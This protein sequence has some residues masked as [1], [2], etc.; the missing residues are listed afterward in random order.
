MMN[1]AAFDSMIHVVASEGYFAKEDEGTELLLEQNDLNIEQLPLL[2]RLTSSRATFTRRLTLRGP[3]MTEVEVRGE[4]DSRIVITPLRSSSVKWEI[5]ALSRNEILKFYY[6][7]VNC[8]ESPAFIN[9]LPLGTVQAGYALKPGEVTSSPEKP[10]NTIEEAPNVIRTDYINPLLTYLNPLYL[11]KSREVEVVKT[12]FLSAETKEGEVYLM[13]K[14]P[15]EVRNRDGELELVG[16]DSVVYMASS[17]EFSLSD[18]LTYAIGLK[19]EP[20]TVECSPGFR[21]SLYSV[22]PKSVIPLGIEFQDE[23]K[24]LRLSLLNLN[25]HAVTATLRVASRI[26][27]TYI[28]PGNN[29]LIPEFDRVTFPIR[30]RGVINLNL[31]TGKLLEQLLKKTVQ[32]FG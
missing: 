20:I 2:L 32:N 29:R 8:R 9:P 14:S 12:V 23:T 26:T 22:I 1:L 16:R 11:S 13:S 27:E 19:N 5:P 24:T 10:R 17:R 31:R 15:F 18:A 25:D 3:D 4:G 6:S 28:W 7:I 30:K 21:F